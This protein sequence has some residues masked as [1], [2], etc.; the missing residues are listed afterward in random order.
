MQ[1]IE[2]YFATADNK[3]YKKY[4]KI[5]YI[6]YAVIIVS[7][8]ITFIFMKKEMEDWGLRLGTLVFWLLIMFFNYYVQDKRQ[9]FV[10]FTSDKII[11]RESFFKKI[12]EYDYKNLSDIELHITK[13]HLKLNS[14]ELK[15]FDCSSFT[16]AN[17]QKLKEVVS[18]LKNQITK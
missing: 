16:Y 9:P 12:V 6:I 5:Q 13:L 11:F 15:V 18:D 7:Y 4:L 8:F 17:I 1:E 14:S 2:F 3:K 10:K